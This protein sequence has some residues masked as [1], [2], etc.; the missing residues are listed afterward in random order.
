MQSCAGQFMATWGADTQLPIHLRLPEPCRAHPLPWH[1]CT[2]RG[3][4]RAVAD[5]CLVI[6]ST[7][8]PPKL[9][10]MSISGKSFR[11]DRSLITSLAAASRVW[12]PRSVCDSAAESPWQRRSATTTC[13]AANI[14]RGIE[15]AS[16]C[17]SAA[18]SLAAA[19][20]VRPTG[21]L[22]DAQ[23]PACP[24]GC[25]QVNHC[26]TVRTCQCGKPSTSRR[27]KD[28]MFCRLP[29]MPCTSTAVG[30]DRPGPTSL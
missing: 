21:C 9:C 26:H 27:A 18:C 14:T 2:G 10:P 12:G 16:N 17:H 8:L 3:T 28:S 24:Q 25:W 23:P 11:A 5:Q 22:K 1:T 30:G 19:Q 7:T 4:R 20:K 29:R 13:G 6:C 15:L